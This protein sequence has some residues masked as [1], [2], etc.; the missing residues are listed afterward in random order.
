M[1]TK[2]LKCACFGFLAVLSGVLPVAAQAKA[3]PYI[4]LRRSFRKNAIFM[5]SVGLSRSAKMS[6]LKDVQLTYVAPVNEVVRG[7]I[8]NS[9]GKIIRK[10]DVLATAKDTKEQIIVNICNQKVK[11]GKLALKDAK[12]NLQRIEKLYKR[13]VFS[14]RQ[15][16]EAENE[17][18]QASSDYDVCRLELLDAKSNLDNKTLRAPFSG[19]VEKVF[20]E[21][22]S[23]S[24]EDKEILILS[25]FN[26]AR[27]NV[28]LHDVLTDLLCVNHNFLVY[29]T[30]FTT[31]SA[32]WL[33]TQEI[34]TD[35]IEL[36]VKNYLVPKRKLTPAQK[37]LPKIYT[38]MRAIKASENPEIP[39]WVPARSIK[40]D[41]K[42]FYVWTITEQSI[43]KYH[44][45][46]EAP[47]LTV[48]KARVKSKDMFIQKHSAQY[49]ALEETGGLKNSQIVLI[50]TD[51]FLTDGGKA[52]MQDS[53]WLFQ[54]SEKVWVSIPELAEYMY[55]VSLD[56]VQMFKGRSFL[57]VIGKDS[58]VSP[59]EVFVYDKSNKT[60]EIIGKNLETGMKIVCIKSSGLLHLGQKVTL[61]NKINY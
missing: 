29:P 56:A 53:S 20:A 36:S 19:V 43:K 12:L 26:P 17:Y 5:G 37:K 47:T 39:L 57:F 3:V 23:S 31:P 7:K 11:K 16:E 21:E 13:H 35:Y 33:K 25:V 40:E 45:S 60:A 1:K 18:L 44:N 54:P 38:R 6:F 58:K 8:I 9:K 51:D 59:V 15:H 61:G 34:F 46:K 42:G 14:E 10:G 24:Y 30:G 48:R 52:I 22:G 55:T 27:V 2:L 41:S 32:G 4:T 49:Q 28:K 50:K